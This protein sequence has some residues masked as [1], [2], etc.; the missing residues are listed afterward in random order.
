M[1]HSP[2]YPPEPALVDASPTG[3]ALVQARNCPSS[4]LVIAGI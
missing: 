2:Q 1:E 3:G 4:E